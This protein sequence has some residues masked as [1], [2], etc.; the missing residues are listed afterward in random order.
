[1]I[2]VLHSY[3]NDCSEIKKILGSSGIYFIPVVNWD[4]VQLIS[5]KFKKN[6]KV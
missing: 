5:E 3:L 4:S 1:M 6:N 2:R